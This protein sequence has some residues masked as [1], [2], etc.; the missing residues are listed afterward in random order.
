MC[1]VHVHVCV[2]RIFLDIFDVLLS[3]AAASGRPSVSYVVDFLRAHSA[4]LGVQ[5][6][7][8]SS[9]K[10]CV[11]LATDLTHPAYTQRLYISTLLPLLIRLASNS[12]AVFSQF[13]TK[14]L[15]SL[16]KQKSSRDDH[17]RVSEIKEQLVATLVASLVHMV[18]Y[19]H[20]SP[21][22]FERLFVP[23]SYLFLSLFFFF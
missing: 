15:Q 10:L 7:L 17:G 14:I 8:T 1:L 18:T 12:Q 3:S 5:S 22:Q 23:E 6:E 11:S 21:S 16:A 4:L 20:S 9:W 2:V 19:I 13:E